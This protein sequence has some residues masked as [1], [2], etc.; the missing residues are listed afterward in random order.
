MY[1]F[2]LTKGLKDGLGLM[3]GVASRYVLYFRPPA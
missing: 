3:L 1:F 2:N